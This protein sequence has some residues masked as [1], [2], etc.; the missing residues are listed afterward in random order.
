MVDID[1]TIVLRLKTHGANFEVLADPDL[2]LK[3]RSGEGGGIRE[4]LAIEEIFKDAKKGEKAS[5]EQMK[6]IFG[7]SD[8]EDIAGKIIKK[9]EFSLTT[10][11]RRRISEDKKKQVINFIARHAIDPQKR[12]PHPPQR[13][14]LAMNEAKVHVDLKRGVEEQ[15]RGIVRALSPLIPISFSTLRFAVRILAKDHG[16]CHPALKKLGEIKREEWSGE[17]YLCL[18]E[19][20]GGLRDQLYS[21]I[22]NLTHGEAEIKMLGKN[23]AN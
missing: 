9:G 18:I 10:E 4:I 23:G 17:Y 11:Q 16:K 7:T 14:E 15:A 12:I 19:I 21:S 2:A 20:P 1:K 5:E 6:E 8:V 3:Y 13:I 22:N